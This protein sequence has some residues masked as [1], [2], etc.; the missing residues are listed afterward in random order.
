MGR[1]DFGDGIGHRGGFHLLLQP[2]LRFDVIPQEGVLFGSRGAVVEVRG[3]SGIAYAA[4]IFT[5]HKM[6]IFRDDTFTAIG[7]DFSVLDRIF[8]VKKQAQISAKIVFVNK[9]GT[10][11]QHTAVAFTDQVNDSFEQR[12]TGGN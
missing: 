5:L 4:V 2:C 9:D 6:N 3:V 11:L 10:L 1:D 12:V 8:D 7:Q